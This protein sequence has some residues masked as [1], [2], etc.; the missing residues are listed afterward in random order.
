[1]PATATC[2]LES[3]SPYSQSAPIFEKKASDETDDQFEERIWRMRAHVDEKG[4]IV[5]PPTAFATC[6]KNAANKLGLKIPGKRGAT[7]GKYFAGGI[8][9]DGPIRLEKHRRDSV[10]GEPVYVFGNPN[11]PKSGRVWRIYPKIDHWS[12]EIAIAICRWFV[13]YKGDPAF[14]IWEANGYGMEF[15]QRVERSTFQNYYRRKTKDSPLH[16]R[17]TDKAGYWTYKRSSLLGPYREALLEG[18]FNNPEYEAVEELRQYQMGAD[19]E[20]YHVGERDREDPAGAKGAHGDRVISDALAWEASVSFGDHLNSGNNRKNI[21]VMN[22]REDDVSRESFAWR[23]A[24]YL[25][26]IG[27]QK[28]ETTW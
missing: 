15:K 17:H 9:V 24:Q 20:P 14:L 22:V 7:Y 27:K 1:M 2:L 18:Y 12:A 21:N 13:N 3:Q 10:L 11:N 5:I 4:T 26:M 23:R 8:I 6:I 28:Q 25:K 16:S 19:G